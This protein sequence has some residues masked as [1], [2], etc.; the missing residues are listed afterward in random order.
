VTTP[1]QPRY[2]WTHAVAVGV[3]ANIP[4]VVA[5]GAMGDRSYFTALRR[6]RGAPPDWAFAPV[7]VGLNALSLWAGLRVANAPVGT[8]ARRATLALEGAFWGLFAGFAPAFFALRSPI[9]GA[10]DTVASTAVTAAS[11]ATVARVDRSA[12]AALAPRLAWL[13]LASYVSTYIAVHNDDP[14]LGH[15]AN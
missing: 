5:G 14:A 10:V 9:L 8:P 1:D 6:P 7:W 12:A 13:L 2:R 11:V 15:R 3:A 4:S